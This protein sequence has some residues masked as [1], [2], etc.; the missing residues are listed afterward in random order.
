M[1]D[2]YTNVKS[3]VSLHGSPCY[4]DLIR[5]F[6]KCQYSAYSLYSICTLVLHR[7]RIELL[8]HCHAI[9]LIL[10]VIN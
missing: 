5:K 2:T 3:P 9:H 4:Y 1:L 10:S 8:K 6:K 7:C